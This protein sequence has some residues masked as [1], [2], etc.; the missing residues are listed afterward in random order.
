MVLL[1]RLKACILIP[2]V[3]ITDLRVWGKSL[4]SPWQTSAPSS[5]QW[6]GF[7]AT[8]APSNFCR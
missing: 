6:V 7:P 8:L 2:V 4:A 3:L 1:G 5:A